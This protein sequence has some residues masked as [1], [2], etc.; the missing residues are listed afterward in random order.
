[1]WVFRHDTGGHPKLTQVICGIGISG[2]LNHGKW[3]KYRCN[4]DVFYVVIVYKKRDTD[5]PL[6]CNLIS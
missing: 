6:Q 2:G 3:P 5:L 1:M 4:L